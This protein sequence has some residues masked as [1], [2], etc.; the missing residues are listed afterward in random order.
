MLNG[1]W[2]QI[3]HNSGFLRYWASCVSSLGALR[4]TEATGVSGSRAIPSAFPTAAARAT[5]TVV[6]AASAQR[7]SGFEL[8]PEGMNPSLRCVRMWRSRRFLMFEPSLKRNSRPSQGARLEKAD[9]GA[10]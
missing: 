1:L 2:P 8:Y 5:R 7:S 4:D 3:L 10:L 6:C 9:A